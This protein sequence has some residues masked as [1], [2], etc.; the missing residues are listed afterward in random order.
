[1]S[2]IGRL[3]RKLVFGEQM[4]KR[5]MFLITLCL[6]RGS[7]VRLGLVKL[8][9]G[10]VVTVQRML[11]LLGIPKCWRGHCSFALALSWQQVECPVGE[12]NLEMDLRRWQKDQLEQSKHSVGGKE[13]PAGSLKA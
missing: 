11:L 7:S 13:I 4:G 3:G 2:P 5:H 8:S 6:W 12:W 1:V 9:M 10:T